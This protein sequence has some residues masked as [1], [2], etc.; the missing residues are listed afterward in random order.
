MLGIMVYGAGSGCHARAFEEVHAA[1]GQ[2]VSESLI[3]E[4]TQIDFSER[5]PPLTDDEFRRLLPSLRQL[6]PYLLALRDSEVSN[7][8]VPLIRKLPTLMSLCLQGTRLTTTGL[9]QLRGMPRLKY[10]W[11]S[12]DAFTE[13]DVAHLERELSGVDVERCFKRNGEWYTSKEL[14]FFFGE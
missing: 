6:R 3:I 14:K 5:Q 13:R 8:S 9:Q 7:E 2:F 11:V 4:S 12:A 10:I 1:G